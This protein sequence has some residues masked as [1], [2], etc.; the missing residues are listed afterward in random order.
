MKTT[1]V[2]SLRDF[3]IE[4]W[5]EVKIRA[6]KEDST[7]RAVVIAAIKKYLGL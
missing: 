5:R 1:T 6:A 2:V 7:A 3:P 4:L